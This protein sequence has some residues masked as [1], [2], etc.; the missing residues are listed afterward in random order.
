MSDHLPS[1]TT[2]NENYHIFCS[3]WETFYITPKKVFSKLCCIDMRGLQSSRIAIA[4]TT[5]SVNEDLERLIV[6]SITRGMFQVVLFYLKLIAFILSPAPV[7][8]V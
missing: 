6:H 5:F 1:P 8:T 4:I 3:D 2:W 7:T